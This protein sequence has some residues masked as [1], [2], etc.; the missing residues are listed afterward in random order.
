M[1]IAMMNDP[2][3]DP[4]QE[5]NWAIRHGFEA[6]DLTLEPPRAEARR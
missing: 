4:L 2:R 5:L 6:F 3:L 1:K